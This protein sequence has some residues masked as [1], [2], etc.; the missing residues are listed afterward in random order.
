MSIKHKK[1]LALSAMLKS[2]N[3]VFKLFVPFSGYSREENFLIFF[4]WI[5]M[6]VLK[7]VR[8]ISLCGITNLET[9][10]VMAFEEG[11]FVA[12]ESL[13]LL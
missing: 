10:M 11:S 2:K 3:Y 8:F 5:R 4:C 1:F 12:K 7:Y 9:F 6:G 13:D